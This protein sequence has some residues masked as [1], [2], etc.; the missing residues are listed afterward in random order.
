M[1]TDMPRPEIVCHMAT[2]LD[3]RLLSERWP[4]SQETVLNL[5]DGAAGR[6]DAD[7]WIVGRKTMEHY[8]VSGAPCAGPDAGPRPDAIADRKGRNIGICFDRQGRLRPEEGDIDGDH[9]VLVVSE[10]VA[11]EHTEDL[12]AR[13]VSVFFA[14]PEGDDVA[15]V[16][17][18]IQAAFGVQRLLLEGGGRL[19][20]AFLAAG[21]IDETSTLVMPVID[22]QSGVPAIYDHRA[23]TTAQR[24]DL[25]STE[26]FED[27]TV[28][29]RH[30]VRQT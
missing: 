15:G 12:A 16:L 27:G 11:Q 22:G 23:G 26:I 19:N 5:Y 24:M 1:S 13:G 8:L 30:R 10:R 2:T 14:G 6:L 21:L 7:G 18:R 9:L 29:L 3:G 25:I 28:W 4:I 20:G 17:K